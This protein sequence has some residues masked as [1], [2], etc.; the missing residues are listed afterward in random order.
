MENSGAMSS[1]AKLQ[2]CTVLWCMSIKSGCKM[3]QH[4]NLSEHNRLSPQ[5]PSC[6]NP[7]IMCNYTCGSL[8]FDSFFNSWSL[9]LSLRD[10][11]YRATD[12]LRESWI[13]W[14][15]PQP[16]KQLF[17]DASRTSIHCQP[18]LNK[19]TFFIGWHVK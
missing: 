4:Y 12:T 1:V 15:P 11:R 7:G 2:E 5:P 3:L 16:S 18:D 9:L 13:R 19:Q 6:M 17:K 14:C 8:Y 10:L